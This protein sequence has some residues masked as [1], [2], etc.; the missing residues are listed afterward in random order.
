MAPG[1]DDLRLPVA[2][3]INRR[4]KSEAQLFAVESS[5][6]MAAVDK[7]WSSTSKT[8]YAVHP[9]MLDVLADSTGYALPTAIFDQLPHI[10]PLFVF[11]VPV[12]TVHP[13][14]AQGELLGFYVYGRQ[15]RVRMCRTHDDERDA[16]GFMFVSSLDN[17]TDATRFTLPLDGERFVAADAVAEG[18]RS[19]HAAP[20]TGG[21]HAAWL[22]W[23]SELAR[24]AVNILMYVCTDEAEVE[25]VPRGRRG[26]GRSA[27]A[28]P[29]VLKLGWKLAPALDAARRRAESLQSTGDGTARKPH[30]R[31]GHWHYY[32]TGTGRTVPLLKFVKPTWVHRDQI[33]D[34]VV[35]VHPVNP[36]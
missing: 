31:R 11:P 36:P 19:F 21:S 24:M 3:T 18:M 22:E 4:L 23:L 12:A 1:D 33:D 7:L 30:P 8:V 27:K 16:L 35:T 6:V 5:I 20:D 25:A 2:Q 13:D 34:A 26:R 15:G 29:R 32:W 9:L 28:A 10:N 17:D 14:G